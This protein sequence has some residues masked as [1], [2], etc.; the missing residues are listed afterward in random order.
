MYI[1]YTTTQTILSLDLG[2]FLPHNHLVFT[3]FYVAEMGFVS[4]S[5]KG[6]CDDRYPLKP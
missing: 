3:V 4:G 6:I 2:S 1:N 5:V